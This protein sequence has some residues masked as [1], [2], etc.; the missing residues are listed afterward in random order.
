MPARLWK[1]IFLR[2][3]LHILGI[4]GMFTALQFLPLADAVAIVFVMPFIL[5]VLGHFVL[6]EQ[7][8]TRRMAAC[9]V[10]FAGTLLV[11]QPSF[12]AVGW[13]ALLPV[14]VAV[15]FALFIL[16]T[17][18]VAKQID[19]ITLQAV[20]GL[21]A[22]PVL[23]PLLGLGIIGGYTP[24]TLVAPTVLEAQLLLGIGLLGTLSHLLMS[25]SLRFA[26]S[27]TLAP[28][29]YLEIPFATLIGY[30]LFSELPDAL[31]TLGITLT[32]G[33][34]VHIVM[35]EQATARRLARNAP[36]PA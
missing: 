1:L 36:P 5:L 13:A 6:H 2:T 16:M 9:G 14:G 22:L 29:Q 18:Q 31:A 20:S 35:R 24:L 12:L 17:R 32:I 26:P 25:W 11:V 8:G 33:A 34:G 23:L 10:G 15:I 3:L 4:G 28:M 21:L 7:I 30:L 19:P 27:A